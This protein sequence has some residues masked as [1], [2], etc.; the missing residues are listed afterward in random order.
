MTAA[1]PPAMSKLLLLLGAISVL[2]PF[3]ID[4]YLPAMPAIAA[5]LNA[6][7]GAIQSTLPAFFVGMA[8]S[9][10]LFGSLADHFGRRPPLLWG[11]TLLAAGGA[12]CA[13]AHGATGLVAWRVVSALGVGSAGVIP[14]AVVRDSFDVLHTARALSLL[15]LITGLGPILA[16]QIG[17]WMLPFAG[18]RAMFWLL[19]ALAAACAFAAYWMLAESLPAQRSDLAG[20]RLWLQLITDRRFLKYAVPATLIQS[21]M[22]A[23]IAGASFVF[24]EIMKLT[25]QQFAWVFGVNAVGLMAAGRINARIVTRFGPEIIFRR[26]MLFTAAAGIVLAAVAASGGFWGLALPQFIFVSLLGFNFA[27][28]FALALAP[29]GESAG[30]ASALYGTLQFSFAGIGG[31]AVSALYDGTARAMAAVMCAVTLAAVAI[32]RTMR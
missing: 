17:G 30:T 27:N 5:D 20:P 15:G 26:A 14:R 1:K 9:Q 6:S 28:G 29:F 2:A 23:Y 12:G 22:F 3:S 7:A 13:L 24:I 11:L 4:M 8:I 16:P 25:P 31:A 32:Y 21:S 19:A 10:L 18:W